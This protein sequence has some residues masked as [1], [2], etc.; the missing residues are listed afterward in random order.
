MGEIAVSLD[1]GKIDHWALEQALAD[2]L[3]RADVRPLD[4]QIIDAFRSGEHRSARAMARAIGAPERTVRYRLQRI[5][6]HC[7]KF[8]AR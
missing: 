5:I 8:V 4:L 6:E 2:Y 1:P 3:K 7:K